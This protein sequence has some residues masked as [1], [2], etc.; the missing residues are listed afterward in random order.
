MIL[1]T[2][3]PAVACLCSHLCQLTQAKLT[4]N[5]TQATGSEETIHN[6]NCSIVQIYHSGGQPPT[7]LQHQD[8][9]SKEGDCVLISST[10]RTVIFEISTK[11]LTQVGTQ[12]RNS[13]SGACF[14]SGQVHCSRPG[15]RIW[16]V[17]MSG[18]VMRT[19]RFPDSGTGVPFQCGRVCPLYDCTPAS[20]SSAEQGGTDHNATASVADQSSSSSSSP[21]SSS[22][23]LLS[24]S[25]TELTLLHLA[26]VA[27]I[28][29]RS[30]PAGLWTAVAVEGGIFVLYGGGDSSENPQR[31][32]SAIQFLKLPNIQPLLC[33]QPCGTADDERYLCREEDWSLQDSAGGGGSSLSTSTTTS[34]VLT[35][36]AT[37]DNVDPVAVV[38]ERHHKKHKK[39]T[40]EEGLA[41]HI[42]K[43][44][45]K[46]SRSP[47][48]H[49]EPNPQ[50]H[51]VFSDET[52]AKPEP[53][54]RAPSP[55]PPPP[56]EPTRGEENETSQV[57]KNFIDLQDVFER[58]YSDSKRGMY[59]VCPAS[60]AIA[61]QEVLSMFTALPT[62]WAELDWQEQLDLMEAE[63][64]KQ[65]SQSK[66]ID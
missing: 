60:K 21:S 54:V 17:S 46:K 61:K 20:S 22:V 48:P 57:A 42:K 8:R 56:P 19:L 65:N 14:A 66:Q 10:K 62:S 30:Y 64:L 18:K 32:N 58:A 52:Q 50:A 4:L 7:D 3:V 59:S 27:P 11:T 2:P 39:K 16:D 53:P 36:R 34:E 6:D 63:V 5:D 28:L 31:I 55:P 41:L 51:L 43:K 47:P 12:A 45:K 37:G 35:P 33:Q 23:V 44:K 9:K 49:T 26:K 24:C 38:K 29:H 13:Y 1:P 40:D 25:H 15:R